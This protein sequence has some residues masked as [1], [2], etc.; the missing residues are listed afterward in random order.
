MWLSFQRQVKAM[1]SPGVESY[2]LVR[3]EQWKAEHSPEKVEEVRA[4]E[5][6]PLVLRSEIAP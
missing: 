6:Q 3:P 1:V 4:Q 2:P 5:L